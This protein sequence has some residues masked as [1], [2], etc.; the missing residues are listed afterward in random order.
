MGRPLLL[1]LAACATP[2]C[3]AYFDIQ[4]LSG[5]AR[6]K[7]HSDAQLRSARLGRRRSDGSRRHL[8]EAT[9]VE[10][11][12]SGETF[13]D[14]LG[15]EKSSPGKR[16]AITTLIA[17]IVV[18]FVCVCCWCVPICEIASFGRARDDDA[19]HE[20]YLPREK[21]PT[22]RN[23]HVGGGQTALPIA[24]GDDAYIR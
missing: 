13:W 7:V 4:L 14:R 6:F 16:A 3:V 9:A 15:Q 8:E 18:A 24:A 12:P 17:V 10:S 11:T 19:L 2:A 23:A 22:L 1:V 21:S 5:I 20:T